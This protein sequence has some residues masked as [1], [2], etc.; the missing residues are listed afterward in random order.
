MA[1]ASETT[2]APTPG[3]RARIFLPWFLGLLL[4][5]AGVFTLGGIERAIAV[6]AFVA[7]ACGAL[8]ALSQLRAAAAAMRE[9]MA[10]RESDLSTF[11]DDRAAAVARQFAWAVDELV[12]VRAELR[13]VDELRA[14]AE[15]RVAGALDAARR[16]SL[17]LRAAQ[18]K[19]SELDASEVD[20]LRQRLEEAETALA[21]QDR[22]RR[23]AEKRARAAEQRAAELTRALRLVASTVSGDGLAAHAVHTGPVTLDW[24]LEYDGSSHSL[25][26]RCVTPEL[27]PSR[28]RIV[29]ATGRPVAESASSRQRR[30]AQLVLRVP[31]SVAAAVESGDWSA[32]RLEAL[33]DEVWREATLVN[34]GE[35]A[36][37]PPARVYEGQAPRPAQIRIVS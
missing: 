21:Q 3:A 8:L 18:E 17:E 7:A 10:H 11:A 13:R 33:I 29:D 37:E 26:L 28:V 1:D 12:G 20:R 24:T 22:E 36:G 19:L 4:A 5:G 35:A 2:S 27:R 16:D 30:P 6:G 9:W 31:Q 15:E 34:R 25:R 32:F 14:V 23:N